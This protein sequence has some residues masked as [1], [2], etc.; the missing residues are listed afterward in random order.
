MADEEVAQ[1]TGPKVP[2]QVVA[3]EALHP[4]AIMEQP[5]VSDED[6]SKGDE[7]VYAVLLGPASG[8]GQS[9][10]T[11]EVVAK[12]FSS[13]E[14]DAP[15]DA[16]ATQVLDHT[17]RAVLPE[18]LRLPPTQPASPQEGSVYGS[19]FQP[20]DVGQ[21][22]SAFAPSMRA[23]TDIHLRV[24]NKDVAAEYSKLRA[25][26]VYRA[27]R[28]RH[29]TVI[30]RS[31]ERYHTGVRM[32]CAAIEAMAGV[33]TFANMYWSPPNA[34]GPFVGNS[35]SAFKGHWDYQV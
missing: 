5:P 15:V 3:P 18:D 12:V 25:A 19:I 32:L 23:G 28:D 26:D 9:D 8:V 24:N 17:A 20:A 31:I 13:A 33:P 27:F 35:S 29:A 21:I 14:A 7:P 2:K 6:R 4:T 34:D 16:V 11:A 22:L 1:I 30:V 10:P